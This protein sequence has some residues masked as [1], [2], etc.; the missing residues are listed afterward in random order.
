M[1]ELQSRVADMAVQMKALEDRLKA[2]ESKLGVS[3]P[4]TPGLGSTSPAAP[5]PG[6]GSPSGAGTNP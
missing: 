4:A 2:L 3:A 6:L 1:A 5:G